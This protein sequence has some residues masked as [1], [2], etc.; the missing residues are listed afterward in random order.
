MKCRQAALGRAWHQQNPPETALAG[1]SPA[2]SR[3]FVLP[4][5]VLA[6]EP[7]PLFSRF[8]HDFGRV[9][10][11]FFDFLNRGLAVRNAGNLGLNASV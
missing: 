9:V 10:I 6:S 4:P 11:N 7:F 8:F 1:K 5:R 3:S 2:C